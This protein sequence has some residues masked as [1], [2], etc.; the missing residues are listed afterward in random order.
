MILTCSSPPYFG[1]SFNQRLATLSF[2]YKDND[3]GWEVPEDLTKPFVLWWWINQLNILLDLFLTSSRLTYGNVACVGRK[4]GLDHFLNLRYHCGAEHMNNFFSIKFW[5]QNWFWTAV[6]QN[7]L[8]LFRQILRYHFISLI[9]D[10]PR[11]PF[12]WQ[13]TFFNHF[14]DTPRSTNDNVN[15]F[16]QIKWLNLELMTTYEPNRCDIETLRDFNELILDL[17]SQFTRRR[18]NYGVWSFITVDSSNPFERQ[19][20]IN[21]GDQ[22]S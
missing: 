9:D 22:I 2:I 20:E 12:K 5:W 18:Q 16:C 17:F 21:D 6:G 10:Y 19:D 8:N 4:E 13:I 3:W 14:L 7:I 15:T 11:Q 1:D